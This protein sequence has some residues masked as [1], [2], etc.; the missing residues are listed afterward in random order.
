MCKVFFVLVI[1]LFIV[2]QILCNTERGS[3]SIHLGQCNAN[4]K[5]ACTSQGKCS[6]LG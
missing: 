1:S 4:F 6:L 5:G 2:I 3:Q